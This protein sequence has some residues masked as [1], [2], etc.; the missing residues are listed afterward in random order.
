MKRHVKTNRNLRRFVSLLVIGF[1]V[2][3]A[4]G[5]GSG[6]YFAWHTPDAARRLSNRV[7]STW[8]VVKQHLCHN[9]PSQY[10]HASGILSTNNAIQVFF[11]PARDSLESPADAALLNLIA[12]GRDHIFCAFYDLELGTIANALVERHRAGVQVGIVSDSDYRHRPGV[13]RCIEAGIPVVFDERTS[14]MHNKFC[15]VDGRYVWTGSTNITENCMYRNYNNA[16]LIESPELAVNF[17]NEFDEM[18]LHRQFGATSPLNTAHPTV[19]VLGIGIE[20]YFAPEDGVE[21]AII[22][23]LAQSRDRLDF[24]AFVFTSVP[25]AEAMATRLAEGVRVRGVIE[26]RNAGSRH[27]RHHYLRQHGAE[28]H[29]DPGPRTMHHKVI[30]VDARTVMTGSYNFSANAEKRN[31][32]NLI[33]IHNPDIARRFIEELEFIIE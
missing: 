33:M 20:S 2:A 16:V 6:M 21:R 9:I 24:M 26:Q 7:D 18:F 13:R 8:D 22:A 25:M 3:L 32:E 10:N 5:F 4:V 11:V 19:T 30:I 29:L 15:V 27:S 1:C 31:D 12:R 17:R 14:L 23:R 28:V